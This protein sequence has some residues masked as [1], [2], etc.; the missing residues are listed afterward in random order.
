LTGL[1]IDGVQ[2]DN[3]AVALLLT[4]VLAQLQQSKN[5]DQAQGLLSLVL[6]VHGDRI[7]G[8]TGL[9][10]LARQVHA[11]LADSWASVDADIQAIRCMVSLFGQMYT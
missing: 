6:R 8:V 9:S 5:F 7:A 3:N 2:D 1:E 10:A 11:Q 4:Y